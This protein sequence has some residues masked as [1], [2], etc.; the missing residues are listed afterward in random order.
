LAEGTD[1]VS[2]ARS[3]S[4]RRSVTGPRRRA[5]IWLDQAFEL[6]IGHPADLGDVVAVAQQ[7]QRDF[8]LAVALDRGGLDDLHR[9]PAGDLRAGIAGEVAQRQPGRG[10]HDRQ[11]DHDRDHPRHRSAEPRLLQHAGALAAKARLVAANDLRERHQPP[12]PSTR[13]GRLGG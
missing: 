11:R 8:R 2:S 12:I 13:T 4:R 3:A 7:R 10:G 5:S 1:A 6:G 9:H